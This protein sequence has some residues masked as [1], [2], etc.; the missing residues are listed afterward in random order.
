MRE[1]VHIQTGQCG[2]QIGTKVSTSDAVWLCRVALVIK[3]VANRGNLWF[4]VKKARP[5][6]GRASR[7]NARAFCLAPPFVWSLCFVK[8]GFICISIWHY[9]CSFPIIP[10]RS[11]KL[12]RVEVTWN[13]VCKRTSHKASVMTVT[14]TAGGFLRELSSLSP[15]SCHSTGS[16]VMCKEMSETCLKNQTGLPFFI[17]VCKLGAV[18][19][20]RG[21]LDIPL[22]ITRR[23]GRGNGRDFH[24]LNIYLL[25]PPVAVLQLFKANR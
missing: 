22:R 1:I 7:L 15:S 23:N 6:G 12:R 9:S 21:S 25:S 8:L 5:A 3:L 11:E 2:N 16:P 14:M 19:T 13:K 4:F 10:F 20:R 24:H 17:F 18:T